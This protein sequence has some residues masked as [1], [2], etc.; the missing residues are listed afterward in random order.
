MSC[1]PT[2]KGVRYNSIAELKSGIKTSTPKQVKESSSNKILNT[3]L[4]EEIFTEYDDMIDEFDTYVSFDNLNKRIEQNIGFVEKQIAS[5]KFQKRNLKTGDSEAN[6][7]IDE[8]LARYERKKE[9]FLKEFERAKALDSLATL[10]SMAET[11]LK[12][13]RDFATSEDISFAELDHIKTNLNFWQAVGKIDPYKPNHILYGEEELSDDIKERLGNIG[14]KARDVDNLFVKKR[15]DSLADEMVK[16]LKGDKE[17]MINQLL[18]TKDINFWQQQ[19][20]DISAYGDAVLTLVQVH[21]KEAVSAAQIKIAELIRNFE[22]AY[23]PLRDRLGK[24]YDVLQQTYKDGTKTNRL[25]YRFSP[26]FFDAASEARTKFQNS[27]DYK[28][29]VEWIK[30]NEIVMNPIILFPTKSGDEYHWGQSENMFSE[31]SEGLRQEHINELKKTLGEKDFE[32]YRNRMQEKIDGF[33]FQ[34]TELK[35][36]YERQGVSEEDAAIMLRDWELQKSPYYWMQHIANGKKLENSQGLIVKNEG[37]LYAVSIPRRFKKDGSETGYYDPN[38]EKIQSDPQLSELYNVILGITSELSDLL[39]SSK[40]SELGINGLMF[41]RKDVAEL[42]SRGDT[43]GMTKELY[44]QFLEL[45]RTKDL[46]EV[47]NQE[48]DPFTGR[49]KIKARLHLDTEES[50]VKDYIESELI[51]YKTENFKTLSKMSSAERNISLDGVKKEL[52]KKAIAELQK[53]RSEDLVTTMKAYIMTTVM[54]HHKSNIENMLNLISEIADGRGA[55]VIKNGEILKHEDGRPVLEG[56]AQKKIDALQFNLE[57]FLTGKSQKVQAVSKKKIL[58]GKERNRKKELDD[59]L[60]SLEDKFVAGDITRTFYDSNR[61]IIEEQIEKLGGNVAGSK[62]GNMALQLVQLKGI[63]WNI[64]SGINNMAFGFVANSAESA[65]GENFDE[66]A[67]G[68]AR[69]MLTSSMLTNASFNHWRDAKSKKIRAMFELF[70][71]LKD[72]STEIYKSKSRSSIGSK[73]KWLNPFQLTKRGEYIN[74]GQTFIAYML[75]QKITDLNGKEVSVWEAYDNNGQW[76]T[77]EFGPMDVSKFSHDKTSVDDLIKKLHGNYDELSPLMG[78]S[79]VEGRA[80]FQFKTWFP[81]TWRKYFGEESSNYIL[82]NMYKGRYR[83]LY[84]V[85]VTGEDITKTWTSILS[86]FL[87][88][89]LNVTSFGLI[90]NFSDKTAF[91]H[92]SK[93][94]MYNMKRNIHQFIFMANLTIMY[95]VL[96]YLADD[97][98]EEKIFNATMNLAVSQISRLSGELQMYSSP[99]DLANFTKNLFPIFSI[100]KDMGEIQKATVKSIKGDHYLQSGPFEGWWR[101]PKEVGE[102][103]P[104]LAPAMNLYKITSGKSKSAESTLIEELI[105][106]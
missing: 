73:F 89:Y 56:N 69:K 44:D 6:K 91:D 35:K 38:Y 66:Y 25:V 16:K 32:L 76:K 43:I 33:I 28:T 20:L 12:E 57:S 80:L 15:L 99:T 103:V 7:K 83:T 78:K 63:G 4:V 74:Q 70:D 101:V 24:N 8:K 55:F 45:T 29:F 71:V 30:D 61:T 93:V 17:E 3:N 62:V 27:R 42:F 31:Y 58:T 75:F 96:K 81:E 1:K 54:Y 67:L 102:S 13:Y 53:E 47:D 10:E 65:A 88:K 64:L 82:G 106:P 2:Y 5:L 59:L 36:E 41:L 86:E 37:Y 60:K 46:N 100:I 23:E 90:P 94:D 95:Y 14:V 104:F 85:A 77:E 18:A 22:K 9:E 51:K 21:E 50:L 11:Q 92:L 49:V 40:R 87:R 72:A 68:Q 97:D 26:E 84:D 52:K 98:G 34:Y 105:Q 39:P 19:A 79:T 48:R